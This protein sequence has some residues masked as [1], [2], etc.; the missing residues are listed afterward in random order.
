MKYKY[1]GHD[2]PVGRL[3]VNFLLHSCS[4]YLLLCNEQEC[5]SIYEELVCK[6]ECIVSIDIEF[7]P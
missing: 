6:L 3:F 7:G 2:M 1:C 5:T 4:A